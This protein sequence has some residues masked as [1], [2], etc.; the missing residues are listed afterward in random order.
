[1]RKIVLVEDNPI[2]SAEIVAIFVA[3]NFS[4][5]VVSKVEDLRSQFSDTKV[6]LL[7][8]D[9]NL[10]T[11]K[12]LRN[13]ALSKSVCGDTP[14]IVLTDFLS[15]ETRTSILASGAINV[16]DKANLDSLDLVGLAISAMDMPH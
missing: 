4:I 12:S 6:D 15:P 1:M 11:T 10:P 16:L 14:I 7:L 2:D 5:A 3:N 8:L 13:L 9:I